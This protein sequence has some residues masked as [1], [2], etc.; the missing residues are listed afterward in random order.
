[1][2][3]D[4]ARGFLADAESARRAGVA[5]RRAALERFGLQRFL[6]DWDELLAEVAA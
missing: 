3:S 5:A 6:A 2:L 4:A 1:M